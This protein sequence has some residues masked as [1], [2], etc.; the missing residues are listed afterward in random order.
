MTVWS[1]STDSWS[2]IAKTIDCHNEYKLVDMSNDK[3][4]NILAIAN[5]TENDI[6]LVEYK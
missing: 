5:E 1:L 6:V 3:E 2:T 4:V